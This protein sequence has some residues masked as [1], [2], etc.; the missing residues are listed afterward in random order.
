MTV[1]KRDVAGATT[2]PEVRATPVGVATGG[3]TSTT[4]CAITRIM[5]DPAAGFLLRINGHALFRIGG[6]LGLATTIGHVNH[7]RRA[8]DIGV[9]E[10][11]PVPFVPGIG[12]VASAQGK[13]GTVV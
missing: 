5:N 7:A 10:L 9:P 1:D 3:D 6:V 12:P 8:A 11:R 4:G 2:M 13:V